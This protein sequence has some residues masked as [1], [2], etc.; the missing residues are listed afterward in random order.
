MPHGHAEQESGHTGAEPAESEKRSRRLNRGWVNLQSDTVDEALLLVASVRARI[1]SWQR[2]L[3]AAAGE[4]PASAP[5]W[6]RLSELLETPEKSPGE[7]ADLFESYDRTSTK[8]NEVAIPAREWVLGQHEQLMVERLREAQRE[9]ENAIRAAQSSAEAAATTGNPDLSFHLQAS[10]TA[11]V[12][13]LQHATFLTFLGD[14]LKS[15]Y[16]EPRTIADYCQDWGLTPAQVNQLW[17]WLTID[18]L[19][20]GG[21]EL[22]IAIDKTNQA[23]YRKPEGGWKFI[24]ATAILWGAALVF[25]VVV[26]LFAILNWAGVTSWPREQWGWKMLVLFV[27]VALGAGVHLGSRLININ[28]D[29]PIKIYEAGTIFDWLALRWI[30]ML[31]MYLP[32]A[33]VFASL[34]GAGDVPKTFQNLGTAILA[35]YTADSLLGAAV[36]KLQSQAKDKTSPT[37]S[38]TP[39]T[40][41]AVATGPSAPSSSSGS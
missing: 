23:A 17:G 7:E 32:V 2:A 30:G 21:Q 34:W 41:S 19:V 26:L 5:N 25:G 36:S 22:P 40:N 35:G 3:T 33:F 31:Q 9:W 8:E 14:T 20:F 15:H 29:N 38:G 27:F 16:G 28:Y 6:K 24:F 1:P 10:Q 37:S 4:A 11:L 18:P 12:A 13:A 39:R